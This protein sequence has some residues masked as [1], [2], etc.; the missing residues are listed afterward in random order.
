VDTPLLHDLW[1]RL[2]RL[3]ACCHV[4]AQSTRVDDGSG[5]KTVW[6]VVVRRR[7][8]PAANFQVVD[9]TLGQALSLAV[10]ISE[11]KRWPSQE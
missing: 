1:D 5:E 9:S 6:I 4:E 10:L 7:D 8:D 2:S 11:Q 3:D